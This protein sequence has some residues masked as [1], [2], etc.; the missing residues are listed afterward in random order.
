MARKPFIAQILG[1]LG[2]IALLLAGCA[3]A[4]EEAVETGVNRSPLANP[5]APGVVY[6]IE[7]DD[8]FEEFNRSVYKFNAVLD[9][10]AFVPVVE[11]YEQITPDFV[12]QRISNFFI[13]IG[14]ITTF[15]NALLQFEGHKAIHTLGRFTTNL[16]VGVLGLFDP[17]TR[18]G[19]PQHKEDFGQTLGR[20]GA[21]DGPYMI[22]PVLGPSNLRDTI[23]FLTDT[24]A[25]SLVDP[26]GAS[27]IQSKY[28]PIMALNI[29][30]NRHRISF[31]YYETGSPFEYDLIRLAYTKKRRLDIAR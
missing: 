23:G 26:L 4:P 28:P 1:G 9:N 2:L 10:V 24:I 6:P 19:M 17:A 27:S 29:I 3:S 25:F 13:N 11:A 5:D 31:R 16:T 18:L 30:D 12:E 15:A 8:P 21:G 22:L 14:N 20:W 7:V